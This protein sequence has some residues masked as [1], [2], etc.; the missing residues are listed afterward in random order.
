[1]SRLIIGI[2][3][4]LFEHALYFY[5]FDKNCQEAHY[6]KYL[7]SLQGEGIG[8]MGKIPMYKSF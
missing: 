7:N 8:L 2:G 4:H 5:D 3:V 6:L 1:M